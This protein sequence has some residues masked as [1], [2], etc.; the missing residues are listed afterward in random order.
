MKLKTFLVVSGFSL[1]AA[2]ICLASDEQ[3]LRDLDT[4]WAAAAAAK[5]LDKTVSYYSDDAIVLPPNAPAAMTKD[6]IRKA[7]K[8]MFDLP[9]FALT[10]TATKVEIAKSGDMAYLIG[11]YEMAFNNGTRTPAKDHGKYLEVFKKQA[12]GKWKC[13]A[14][15]FSSDLPALA[16]E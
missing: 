1:A 3:A 15:M 13:A 4:Q 14:D 9:G 6:T 2:A 7:W 8:D 11:A 10:W 12:D 5:D 16:K